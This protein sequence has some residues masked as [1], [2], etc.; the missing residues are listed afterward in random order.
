VNSRHLAPFWA[1]RLLVGSLLA[2][3][4]ASLACSRP[5]ATRE[6]QTRRPADVVFPVE[7]KA[8]EPRRIEYRVSAVGALEAFENVQVTARVAGVLERLHFKEGDTLKQGALLAEIE[9]QRFQLAVA[10]AQATLERVKA[11]KAEAER[12]LDRAQKLAAEGLSTGA[13]VSTWQTRLATAQAQESEARA[14]LGVASLNLRDARLKAPISGSIQTRSVQTG[15][16][17]QPGTVIATL[18]RR[19]PLLLRF[20]VTEAEAA[21]LSLGMQANFNVSGS[22]LAHQAK[23]TF[24]A[25]AA[26]AASRM[27]PVVAEVAEDAQ[28]RP[29]AFAEVAVPIGANDAAL[30]VPETAIRPSERGFIAFVVEGAVARERIVELGLRTPDGMV[31]V[32]KGLRVGEQLVVRGGEALKEGAKVKVGAP[33][34]AG[35]SSAR[36][37]G[38]GARP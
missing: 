22:T 6:Q 29:G 8:V 30:A 20:K 25:G 27:V 14:V 5:D 15:Q 12:E 4:H 3:G 33:N 35:S 38:P 2:F 11:S 19:D 13:E 24:I 1:G 23:I 31:E 10:S 34:A 7:L 28:L 26:E 18:I 16:Y 37:A 36:P 21:R 32:V 9:P 17:V